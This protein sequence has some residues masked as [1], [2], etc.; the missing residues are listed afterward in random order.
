MPIA[1]DGRS[2]NTLNA[3]NIKPSCL[4]AELSR[5]AQGFLMRIAIVC[6]PVQIA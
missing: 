1:R 2:R 6:G 5:T 3:A 4:L